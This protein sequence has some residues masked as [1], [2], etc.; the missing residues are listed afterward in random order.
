MSAFSL[1]AD[2]LITSG[3][4]QNGVPTNV[5]L[6]VIVS[7]NYRGRVRDRGRVRVINY[8]VKVRVRAIVYS[9]A[10]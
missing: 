6:F 2:C 8:S 3:A 4:I 9:M 7:V 10:G 5:V 1:Y